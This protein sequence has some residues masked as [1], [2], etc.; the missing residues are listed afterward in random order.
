MRGE[1]RRWRHREKWRRCYEGA[2]RAHLH[3]LL[4]VLVDFSRHILKDFGPE[5]VGELP[6]ERVNLAVLY[7]ARLRALAE[8]ATLVPSRRCAPQPDFQPSA[9]ARKVQGG[10]DHAAGLQR[11]T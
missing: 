3:R 8:L 6:V 10:G 1:R 2:L 4:L 5:D 11:L 7:V 9:Q